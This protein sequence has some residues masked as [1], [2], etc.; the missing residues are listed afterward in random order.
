MICVS[1]QFAPRFTVCQGTAASPELIKP[2]FF[3]NAYRRLP[4][5]E[6]GSIVLASAQSPELTA[7]FIFWGILFCVISTAPSAYSAVKVG[8][9][10]EATTTISVLG[11]AR[12]Y[13]RRCS[14]WRT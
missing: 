3:Q 13:Q 2:T 6:I 1:D 5:S 8:Q 9:G 14:L 7:R 11:L 12:L 4:E 10:M